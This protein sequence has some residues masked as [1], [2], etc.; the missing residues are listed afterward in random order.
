MSVSSCCSERHRGRRRRRKEWAHLES[1]EHA[2][3]VRLVDLLARQLGPL[4]AHD[5]ARPPRNVLAP[6]SWRRIGELD[7]HVRAVEEV[8]LGALHRR[9]VLVDALEREGLDEGGERE[10]LLVRRVARRGRGRDRR[11]VGRVGRR[12]LR[13]PAH[14]G[15]KVEERLGLVALGLQA[16]I[17]V[18]RRRQDYALR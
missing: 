8:E 15:D 1:V 4:A 7:A 18:S 13:G 3:D 14:E 11:R 9:A 6:S 17:S 12:R 5:R 16:G 2:R 10:D